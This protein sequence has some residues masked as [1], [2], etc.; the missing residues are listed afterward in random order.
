MTIRRFGAG[1]CWTCLFS[2]SGAV[3]YDHARARGAV[4][5]QTSGTT[6][7]A[8][9]FLIPREQTVI[10]LAYGWRFWLWAGH[11]GVS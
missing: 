5:I 8:T 4:L 11:R 9:Q 6:D 3:S 10:E 7:E 2:V 1:S